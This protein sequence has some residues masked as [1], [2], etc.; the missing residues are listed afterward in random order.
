LE[1]QALQRLKSLDG[2]SDEE[3]ENQLWD[4]VGPDRMKARGL[5]AEGLKEYYRQRNLLKTRVLAEHVG[6]VVAFF[7][8]NQTPTTGATFPIDGGIPAAFPR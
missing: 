1:L 3:M 6:N 7:A 8:G 5:D 2:L 4:L